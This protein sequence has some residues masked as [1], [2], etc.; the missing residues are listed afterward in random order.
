MKG[1]SRLMGSAL[2]GCLC[3]VACGGGGGS[4][5]SFPQDPYAKCFSDGAP[6]DCDGCLNSNCSSPL[7]D[8]EQ[9]CPDYLMCACPGGDY[10]SSGASSPSCMAQ[11]TG[12][13]TCDGAAEAMLTCIKAS[14]S[15]PCGA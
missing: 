5:S 4:S 14:C 2:A 10:N 12:N 8:F 1:W 13:S 9:A 15:A 6:G 3:L 11:I 7:V